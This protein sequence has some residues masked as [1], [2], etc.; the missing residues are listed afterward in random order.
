VPPLAPS[1]PFSPATL[2]GIVDSLD[3]PLLAIDREGMVRLLN[4]AAERW[5]GR[6]RL[7]V[8]GRALALCEPWG[9]VLAASARRVLDEGRSLEEDLLQGTAAL[10]LTTSPWWEEDAIVG[11]VLLVQQRQSIPSKQDHSDVA[12]LAAGLAHE[13]RNP[14]AALR[15]AAEL[16]ADE[17]G[18]VGPSVREYVDLILR[19]TGR[20]DGLVGRLL[21]VSRP[22][23]LRRTAFR[24]DEMLH[25]LA[26][27]SRALAQ[28]RGV[29]V[30]IE[31]SY[32]PALPPLQ[33]DRDRLFE[34]LVNL[35]KNAVE[36]LPIGG[37]QLS[38]AAR[39][40]PMRRRTASGSRSLVSFWIRDTGLG[41]GSARDRLFTP[42]FS[43]KPSGTGLG[44]LLARR[45]IEAH[46]GVL[47]LKDRPG[48]ETGAEAH[49]LLPIE[50][51]NG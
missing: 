7:R 20:V 5:L 14:L 6:S 21:T 48:T 36:A 12:A 50:A 18:T 9:N 8:V 46:G 23:P 47:T 31:E 32:D 19:E 10:T 49:V 1:Q 11:A 15:G 24:G 45:I 4:D 34:A 35:V 16:L 41:L 44:L 13:V 2:A 51:S 26:I 43:T 28:A 42:F 38:F 30:T 3:T 40:D 25:D 29:P 33:A 37:G 39:L 17:L 22:V 27:Q